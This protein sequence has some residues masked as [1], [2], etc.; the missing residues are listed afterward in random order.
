MTLGK[1]VSLPSAWTV[2]LGKAAITVALTVTMTFLCRE[3][4]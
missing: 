1:A 4:D 2:A 3:P